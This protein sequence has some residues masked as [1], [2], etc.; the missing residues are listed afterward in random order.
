DKSMAHDINVQGTRNVLELMRELGIPKGVYTSTLAVFSDT[1]GQQVNENYRHNGPWLS[2]YDR[3]KWLAH[4]EVALPMILDG[5]P[6]VIVQPGVNYG[7]G[8]TSSVG[9]LLRQYLRREVMAIPYDTAYC[10]A[11]VDDTARGHIQA[12]EK[13]R[14]GEAYII[15]GPVHT[16]IEAM[17][18]AEKITGIPAP[19]RRLKPRFLKTMATLMALLEKI[20]PVPE[21]YSSEYL[22]TV[23]GVTY[24]GNSDKARKELDFSPRP[25]EEGL[26]ETLLHETKVLELSREVIN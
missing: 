22:R 21:T 1:K 19:K 4:Y 20:Y 6:L 2:E 23:A 9:K 3:T 7:P 11:H 24:L 15:A 13:G 8:D 12:M 17:E 25:L 14:S 16:V 10:W 26:R 5:L 18:I